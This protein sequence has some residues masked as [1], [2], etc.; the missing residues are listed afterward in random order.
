MGVAADA[1]LGTDLVAA[2]TQPAARGGA[3]GAYLFAPRL[4]NLASCHAGLHALLAA[5]EP[6]P[7]TRVLVA[8]DH[9][10][11]GSASAE[12]ARGSFLADVL[13]RVAAATVDDR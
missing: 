4:D 5:T 10:E 11:V 3:G 1:L 2:D 6:T 12:G 8:N 9:E 7:H 13:A